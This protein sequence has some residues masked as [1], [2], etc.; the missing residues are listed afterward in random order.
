[1]PIDEQQLL[2]WP[3]APAIRHYEGADAV[4]FARGFGAGL[5]GA[6]EAADRSFLDGSQ[7]LPMIAVAL[8]D[9][10]FWQR[11]PAAGIDWR[12]IV[13]A[14]EGITVHRPLDPAASVV[15]TQKVAALFDR[16]PDKGAV[17]QQEQLLST[18]DG[19]PLVT[20]DV[21]TVLRGDG[22]FGGKPYTPVRV[23]IPQDR[24]PDALLEVRTPKDDA[25]AIFRI[26]KELTVA[27]DLGPGRSMMRGLGCF[28]LAGRAVLELACAGRPERLK[29][30]TVRYAGPMLTDETMLVELWHME[31][32]RA[33]FRMTAV[34]RQAPVLNNCVL[35]FIP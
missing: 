22:G 28:G 31:A 19:A 8:A 11:D 10:E 26:S 23:Q 30:M 27:A 2:A 21:T 4:R 20:I 29:R 15:L 33:M 6:L 17:M 14:E 32:G 1:V 24:A 35:E 12:G 13:H 18:P 3:F 7:A 5:P 34:E 25:D 9:G 16:G